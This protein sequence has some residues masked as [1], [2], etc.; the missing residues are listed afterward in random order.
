MDPNLT[1]P[2]ATVDGSFR[3]GNPF[4]SPRVPSTSVTA[5]FLNSWLREGR[6]L[7]AAAGLEPSPNDDTQLLQAVRALFVQGLPPGQRSTLFSFGGNAGPE[8]RGAFEQIAHYRGSWGCGLAPA[9]G[10]PAAPYYEEAAGEYYNAPG[11]QENFGGFG[12]R[13]LDSRCQDMGIWLPRKRFSPGDVLW[14]RVFGRLRQNDAGDRSFYFCFDPNGNVNDQ[15]NSWGSNDATVLK[16]TV[17]GLTATVR[18]A[19]CLDVF[20]VYADVVDQL[21]LAELNVGHRQ[22]ISGKRY[23]GGAGFRQTW[24]IDHMSG[25][26]FNFLA[27]PTGAGKKDW[28]GNVM[29]GTRWACS[30]TYDTTAQ[31]N[32]YTVDAYLSRNRLS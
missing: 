26:G 19:A 11:P 25:T 5:R 24:A 29:L 18:T 30:G 23:E 10:A 3:S 22:V 28:G 27:P 17:P 8:E 21:I 16:A 7:L 14:I 1:A 31:F 2:G 32:A 9:G 6:N 4:S 13:L 12:G 20:I 15:Q